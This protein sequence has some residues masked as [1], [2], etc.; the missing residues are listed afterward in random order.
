MGYLSPGLTNNGLEM[1]AEA[2]NGTGFTFT[3]IALGNGTGPASSADATEMANTVMT[4][5]LSSIEQEDNY[6]VLS[7]RFD[8]SQLE[9]GF[10]IKELGVF[11]EQD[12][13]ET[14]QLYAYRYTASEADYIPAKDSGR[15]TEIVMRIIVAIGE[16]DNVSA[17]L[18]D[19]DIYASKQDLSDHIHDYNNPHRV[20]KEQVG[21]GNVP[22]ATPSN[23]TITFT[24]AATLANLT[25]G[26]TLSVLFGLVAKAVHDLIVHLQA[27]NPHN[28]TPAD[29]GASASGHKHSAA[30]I[31][32][33]TLPL[34]R[35]GTGVTS[36]VALRTNV[37]RKITYASST[38]TAAGWTDVGTYSFE[39]TY[40]KN[41]Y[42]VE[43]S[44][45]KTA[46]LVQ[47][48][49][50]SK[51]KLAGDRDSNVVTALGKVPVVDIP[52]ILKLVEVI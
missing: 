20:T 11:A 40:S 38:I 23:M 16:A 45:A 35:G 17:V 28:L 26:K 34:S 12:E 5:G 29:I 1:V 15:I 21:L 8:N 27:S 9:T 32:S 24:R 43:V 49:A 50:F 41:N 3:K 51:A 31:T 30:D 36:L 37:V 4:V 10:Y 52:V 44:I 48:V 7:V 2:M 18:I 22:N 13:S 25:S 47:Q 19:A 39:N 46:T 14:E 33:G 6:V 42:N